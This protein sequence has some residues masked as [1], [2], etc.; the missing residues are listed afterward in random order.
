MGNLQRKADLPPSMNDRPL[1]HVR[2]RRET[3]EGR[4]VQLQPVGQ[5]NTKDVKCK[6]NGNELSARCMLGGLRGPD[7]ND[8]VQN[9]SADTVDEARYN[10]QFCI[11]LAKVFLVLTADHPVMIL[12]RAL[13]TR[14]QDS[15]NRAHSNG[16][17]SSHT[18]SQPTTKQTAEQRPQIVDGHNSTLQQGIGD[19]RGQLAIFHFGVAKLHDVDIVLCI[20]HTSHHSLVISEEKNGKRCDTVD[21]DQKPALLQLVDDI[22]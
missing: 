6:L 11:P 10:R 4:Y 20:V 13:Q 1:Q 16:L 21:C 12:G 19:H 22:P 15:P 9:T 3:R 7:R 17:D 14:T 5:D 2:Q 18:I 8:S